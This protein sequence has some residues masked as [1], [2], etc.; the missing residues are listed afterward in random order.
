MATLLDKIQQN[1]AASGAQSV[2]TTDQTGRARTLLA[3]KSGKQVSTGQLAPQSA[4]G[5]AAAVDPARQGLTALQPQGQL[6]AAEVGQQAQQLGAAEEAGRADLALHKQQALQQNTI[7]KQ[8]LFGEM[9]REG[10]KLDLDRDAAT[11]EQMAHTLRL[12]DKQYMDMLESE[13]QKRRLDS[14]LAFKE[15]LQKS[16][17]GS[18]S[19]L[20]KQSL[21]NKSVLA[22]NDREFQQAIASMDI[23][24]ALQMAANEAHDAQTAAKIG[25]AG[26]LANA[27]VSA[28]GS[29]QEGKFDDNYKAYQDAGGKKSYQG[30]QKEQTGPGMSP[31]SNVNKYNEA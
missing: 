10:R 14:D 20:L 24:A 7:R 29:Q 25:A 21:G 9:S 1:L 22:A 19:D 8:Q 16:I 3:A 11:L 12:S 27:G 13:G 31:Q 23:N 17:L 2:G 4:V 15:E 26:S 30:W 5:E 18:N 28:Y 6:A